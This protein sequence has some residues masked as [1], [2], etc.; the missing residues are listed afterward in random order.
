MCTVTS[1]SSISV[2]TEAVKPIVRTSSSV[3]FAACSAWSPTGTVST[4][5][6]ASAFSSVSARSR[7]PEAASTRR[8]ALPR[9]RPPRRRRPPRPAPGLRGAAGTSLPGSFPRRRVGVLAA[10]APVAVAGGRRDTAASLRPSRLERR[11]P[12]PRPERSFGAPPPF[13]VGRLLPRERLHPGPDPGVAAADPEQALARLRQR[14]RTRARP[15]RRPA[16][17]ARVPWRR[18]PSVR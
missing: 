2:R 11:R 7:S 16:G 10:P 14:P 1:S 5:T 4:S 3:N 18:R 15:R 13:A 12:G 8:A 6:S 9:P 17:R